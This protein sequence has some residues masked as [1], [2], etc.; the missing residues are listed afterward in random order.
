MYKIIKLEEI[1]SP[2]MSVYSHE[3]ISSSV[4]VNVYI[5]CKLI[6]YKIA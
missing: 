6:V 3:R 1:S 5:S 4:S 2:K